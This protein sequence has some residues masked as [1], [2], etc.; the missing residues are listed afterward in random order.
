MRILSRPARL[1]AAL[2][3]MLRPPQ[4][5]VQIV[6]D[7]YLDVIAAVDELPQ[8]DGDTSIQSPI[9][10]VAGGSALNT[11]V[12]LSAL[13]RTRRQSTQSRPIRGCTLHSR[14]GADL[15]GDL[16]AGKIRDAGVALSAARRGGQGVCICLS[17][18]RDR[19]FVSYKGTVAEFNEEDLDLRRLLAPGTSHVHFSAYYDCAGLQPAVPRLVERAR[20]ERGATVSIVPQADPAG[21]W[22]AGFIELLP[23]VDVLLCN[24]REAAAIAG[25]EYA[26]RRPTWA[27]LDETMQR[28][29]GHGAPLVVVTLGSD[30]AIAASAEAM[31]FQPT[32]PVAPVDT[33]GCGDAFA[34]GFLFGWC[35]GRDVR[36]GLVYGCACGAAAVG[37]IGGS[38][39]LDAAAVNACMRRNEGIGCDLLT[40]R[41]ARGLEH[42][43]E[44]LAARVSA[45]V[46]DMACET[47]AFKDLSDC[48]AAAEG[49]E[50][51]DGCLNKYQDD[52][53]AARVDLQQRDFSCETPAFQDLADCL[54]A[55]D[56]AS[57]VEG[58]M[59]QY[60]ASKLQS[61]LEI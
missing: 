12:Q 3:G 57:A 9:E 33:T 2:G 28:L 6:G 8:W 46:R 11:A 14:V 25:V 58:C 4:P 38:T 24:Q 10:T 29:R 53:M 30:G 44:S 47:P 16:V 54:A 52:E 26:G 56:D 19:S 50:E 60:E 49:A 37:Q 59:A 51:V 15:Y 31:W 35:G 27:E 13:L 17:G 23:L 45:Q 61:V 20:A 48:L 42:A 22:Q 43:A 1:L 7:I 55:A 40:Y 36:R 32:T 41:D 34:A 21:E 18:Q 5:T 39:P